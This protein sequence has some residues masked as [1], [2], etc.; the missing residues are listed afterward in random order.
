V[1]A[2]GFE[3]VHLEVVVP[4]YEAKPGVCCAPPYLWQE[5]DV[6]LAAAGP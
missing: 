4:P 5:I 6:E 1:T 2:P 3:P